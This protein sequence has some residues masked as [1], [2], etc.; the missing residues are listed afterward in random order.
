MTPAP[1]H[2]VQVAAPTPSLAHRLWFGW[3]LFWAWFFT[4]TMSPLLVLH[5]A[6]QPTARTIRAW[7]LPWARLILGATRIGVEVEHRAPVPDGPVVFVANHTNSLDIMSTMVALDR[8]FLYM[9][10]HEVRSWPFVGWVLEKTAC[11]FIRRDNPR[12]AVADLRRA[13]ERIQNGDSVLLFPEGGRSHAHGLQPFM[14]GPFVLALEAGVPVVPVSIIGNAGV[15]SRRTACARPGWTRVI[16]GEPLSTTEL[17][18]SDSI[19]LMKQTR[20]VIEDELE[21]Y[22]AVEALPASG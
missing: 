15:L 13:A 9:A 4:A 14:R 21:A 1:P 11:L 12:Q 3:T 7:M 10:R 8:P 6:F 19:A 2:A 16:I 18:R 17:G 20:R 22:G 5:S